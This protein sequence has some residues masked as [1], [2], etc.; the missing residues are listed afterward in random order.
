MAFFRSSADSYIEKVYIGGGA[1]SQKKKFTEIICV[2]ILQTL[3]VVYFYFNF[4]K[5][6]YIQYYTN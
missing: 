4:I 5:Y 1:G 6:S 2:N 3:F